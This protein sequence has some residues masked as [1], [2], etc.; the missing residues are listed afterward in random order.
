MVEQEKPTP[1]EIRR[2]KFWKIQ[3]VYLDATRTAREKCE[4]GLRE[5]RKTYQTEVAPVKAVR[6]EAKRQLV[7]E[8]SEE[9]RLERE[10]KRERIKAAR[11]AEGW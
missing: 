3:Q 10:Q 11:K 5:V 7:R 6:D 2:H 9:R 4:A 8:D 1:W